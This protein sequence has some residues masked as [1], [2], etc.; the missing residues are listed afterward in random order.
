MLDSYFGGLIDQQHSYHFVVGGEKFS[1]NWANKEA[2]QCKVK[3]EDG[4]L[5]QT[6]RIYSYLIEEINELKGT[7]IVE[8][9]EE[10]RFRLE[11]FKF[12]KVLPNDYC[13]S[14]EDIEY[15]LHSGAEGVLLLIPL[16]TLSSKE[17]GSE[18]EELINSYMSLK[19]HGVC[20]SFSV[21]ED[22]YH[23][24]EEGYELMERSESKE[25]YEELFSKKIAQFYL[26]L[27][28]C[29][30]VAL[31]LFTLIEFHSLKEMDAVLAEGRFMSSL[32][33]RLTSAKDK[34]AIA[35]FEAEIDLLHAQAENVGMSL[36]SFYEAGL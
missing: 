17:V 13:F 33:R 21:P 5:S 3:V 35:V 29:N 12:S 28:K 27:E 32:A 14:F 25:Y 6:I 16:S 8:L 15:E 22:R 31:V 11:F 26:K 36:Q 18:I 23:I 20:F 4:T 9:K 30:E 1:L 2:E 10:R 7:L 24:K 19:S 34:R